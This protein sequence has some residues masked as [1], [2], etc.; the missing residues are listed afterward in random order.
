MK[1][2]ARARELVWNRSAGIRVETLEHRCL[3][4]AKLP[5][6]ITIQEIPSTLVSGTTELLI[7]GTKKSDGITINDNGTGTAGNMFVSLSDGRDYV[8]TGAVTGVSVI[9][10]TGNDQV[11]YELDGNLQTPNQE[12]VI[13]GS[14]VKKG[15]GAVQLTVNIAGSILAGSDLSVIGIPDPRKTTAMTVNES[16]KI[17]GDLTAGISTLGTKTLKPAA[18]KL[19]VQST[20]AI[21]PDGDLDLGAVGGKHNDVA[22]IAYS[23]TN[24][25]EIDVFE[26]GNGGSDNL[27]ADIFMIPGSTGTVGTSNNQSLVEGSGKDHLSFTV[28]QGT[29]T[30][31]ASNIFA[32][33]IGKSKRDKVTHTANVIAKTKGKVTLAT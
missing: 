7:T 20:G 11:T 23:G 3:L 24:N 27:S 18:V 32:Q 22:T 14:G 15:G 1:S 17:D 29:D 21:G 31:T 19:S 26:L 6:Q 10:G 12:L 33:I 8:S 28:E 16:G 5:A 30:T 4:A 13:V 9:T 25:G 2:S